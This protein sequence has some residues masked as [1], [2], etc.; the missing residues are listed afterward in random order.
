MEDIHNLV[1]DI[2]SNQLPGDHSSGLQNFRTLL[3]T[4]PGFPD[5]GYLKHQIFTKQCQ[6]GYAS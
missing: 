3:L 4:F 1:S 2:H 5:K 6:K